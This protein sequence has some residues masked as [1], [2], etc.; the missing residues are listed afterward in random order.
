MRVLKLITRVF[1]SQTPEIQ[2]I[3]TLTAKEMKNLAKPEFAKNPENFYPTQVFAKFGFSRAQCKNCN[4]HFWRHTETQHTCGDSNCEGSYKFIGKGTGKGRKGKKITYEEA[5]NGFKKS[6]TNA[7]IPCTAI[8]R[9]PVVA[10][11]RNDVEYVA[12]GIYCFQPYCVTGEMNP[13]ANPLI[14]PQF[15]VRF[16]DLDNIGLTGRHYSGFIMLG[17][18]AFNYPG[19]FVFFKEECVEFNLKW[20]IEELEIDPDEITL[21]E[22]V[23]AGGGNLGPCVEYFIGGLEVGNMVFMQYKTFPDGSREELPIKIIDTGIG[24]ERIPW[25]I[26]GSPTSYMDVFKNSFSWLSEK[27]KIQINSEVWE[28]FGPLSCRLNIDEVENINQT[29]KDISN[30]INIPVE[31]VKN[32]IAPIKDLYIILDH[33]RS[34]LMI[35]ED[36]SLPSNIGGGANVRNILRRVFALLKKNNW[37]DGLKMDGFIELFEKHKNDLKGIYPDFKEHKSFRSIIEVEYERWLQTDKDQKDRLT[38]LLN[39]NKGKL[40]IEDWIVAITSWGIPADRV[41]EISGIP[42][43]GDLYYQISYRQEQSVKAPE[44]ILYD[45]TH[46]PETINLYYSDHKTMTFTSKIIEVLQNATSNGIKNILILKESAFYPTSGGQAHDTG[47][48]FIKNHVYDVVEV[49]KSGHCILHILDRAIEDQDQIIGEEVHGYIDESRRKQLRDHH[50]ATHLIFAACKKVLGPHIWQNGAKKTIDL[51]HLDITHYRSLTHDEEISIEN[52]ANQFISSSTNIKKSFINKSQAESQYGFSLY[53]GGIVPGNNLRVV[54]IQNIDTEAC[55]GTHCDNTAEV[56][57]IRILKSYR[58]SDGIVRLNFVAGDKA[59]KKLNDEDSILYN[60]TKLWGISQNEIL[61]TAERFFQGYKKLEELTRKQQE[62]ILALTVRSILDDTNSKLAIV[63]SD[64]ITPTLYFSI[65][66]E[67]AQ[68]MKKAGKGVVF[69][70]EKFLYGLL[71]DKR[72]LDF[73]GFLE[74]LK[75]SNNQAKIKVQDKVGKKDKGKSLDLDGVVEFS[76]IGDYG[77]D[78]KEYLISQGFKVYE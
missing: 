44:V 5:W 71:G 43:P 33:T 21:I 53:Q 68:D 78:A 77:Q 60:L 40:N 27:L 25:L 35:I 9:Y 16:N 73:D 2:T 15:C 23:W 52:T 29:W 1:S 59:I 72:V 42:P 57:R 51:A 48:I 55:C 49:E 13:P 41:Y 36:G 74:V 50:T 69:V 66:K 14:C 34:L 31:T 7:R 6:F 30:L 3:K 20:L 70:G 37:W 39:K 58:I 12:A 62:K 17:I 26:N 24:L 61:S 38:K 47:R 22:D 76:Y 75:R 19:K 8:E 18:Q 67:H 45:T 4:T 54:N 46:L 28:K 64:Q 32:A 65:L 56:G 63:N 10:R 11:W